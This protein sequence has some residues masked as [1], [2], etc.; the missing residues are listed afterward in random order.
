MPANSAAT[1]GLDVSEL[2]A[3]G[4]LDILRSAGELLAALPGARMLREGE[5]GMYA[6]VHRETVGDVPFIV[7]E[8]LVTRA[9]AEV[10]GEIGFSC[11]LGDEPERARLGAL[12]DAGIRSRHAA[13]D[14]LEAALAEMEA[15]LALR[16]RREAA[17]IAATTVRFDVKPN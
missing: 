11:V 15:D 17:M 14:R 1:R 2:V 13:S 4:S 6:M 3:E 7:G 5:R 12:I 8:L 16:R 9:E 10:N